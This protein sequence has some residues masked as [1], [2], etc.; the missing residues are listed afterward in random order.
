MTTKKPHAKM[1]RPPSYHEGI[2]KISVLLPKSDL[3]YI[4]TH[5]PAMK[6][7][8]KMIHSRG[9]GIHNAIARARSYDVL[10]DGDI[11]EAITMLRRYRLMLPPMP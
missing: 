4:R 5:A 3:D 11:E 10:M 9:R 1:G 2:T 7:G 6:W 8:A